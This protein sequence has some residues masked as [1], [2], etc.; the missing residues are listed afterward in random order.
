MFKVIDLASRLERWTTAYEYE[1]LVFSVSNHGR[2][3]VKVGEESR[4]MSLVEAV[5]MMGRVSETFENLS[6]L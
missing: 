5:S 1:D 4:I 2:I 3:H 6:G